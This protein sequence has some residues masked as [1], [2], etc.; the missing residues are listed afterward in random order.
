MTHFTEVSKPRRAQ[1]SRK[2]RFESRKSPVSIVLVSFTS[3]LTWSSSPA[4]RSRGRRG[5]PPFPNE[6]AARRR[7][8]GDQLGEEIGMNERLAPVSETV[9][10]LPDSTKA[11]AATTSATVAGFSRSQLSPSRSARQRAA[12]SQAM[13]AVTITAAQRANTQPH[14]A[15]RLPNESPFPWMERKTSTRGPCGFVASRSLGAPR[16]RTEDRWDSRAPARASGARA[17]ATWRLSCRPQPPQEPRPSRPEPPRPSPQRRPSREPPPP[18]PVHPEPPRP[19][20][21]PRLPPSPLS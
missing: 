10:A 13:L 20:P 6:R 1:V 11:S 8:F 16:R 9:R 17:I 14:E 3:A 5:L 7:G 12:D 15:L 21:P 4:R 18:R 2:R 19:A